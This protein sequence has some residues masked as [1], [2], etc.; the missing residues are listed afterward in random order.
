MNK[1]SANPLTPPLVPGLFYTACLSTVVMGFSLLMIFTTFFV[2]IYTLAP[3]PITRFK[4]TK[5]QEETAHESG[6][7]FLWYVERCVYVGGCVYVEGCVYVGGCVC[8]YV[9]GVVTRTPWTK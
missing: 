2:P 7:G 6:Y 3:L 5:E 1:K 9:W 4:K 8:V